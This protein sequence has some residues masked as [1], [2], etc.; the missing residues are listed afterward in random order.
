MAKAKSVAGIEAQASTAKNAHI[1]ARTRLEEMIMWGRYAHDPQRSNE[2]HDLRIAAKRLRYTLE[3]FSDVLPKETNSIIA[4]V[5]QIQEELGNLHDSDVMIALLNLCLRQQQSENNSG[6]AQHKNNGEQAYEAAVA[7][8]QQAGKHLINNV[9]LLTYLLDA[10]TAPSH[11]QHEG[12]EC[13]L[14]NTQQQ[15]KEAYEAFRAHWDQLQEQGFQREVLNVLD[16]Q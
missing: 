12:L 11:A 1:I 5:T 10:R 7:A 8:Q 14:V 15:R 2:L 6:E 9:E 13:L 16:A 3:I 4:E